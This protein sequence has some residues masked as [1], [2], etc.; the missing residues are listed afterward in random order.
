MITPDKVLTLYRQARNIDD[1]TLGVKETVILSW[2]PS[3]T[4]KFVEHFFAIENEQWLY[5]NNPIYTTKIGQ[6]EV[7]I[8][9]LKTGASASAIFIENL[10][11]CGAKKIICVGFSG[12]LQSDIGSGSLVFVSG[13][14]STEGTSRHYINN[15]EDIQPSAELL[16]NLEQSAD[17]QNIKHVKGKLWSTDALYR[18]LQSDVIR[19]QNQGVLGVDMESSACLAVAQ[20]NKVDLCS[21]QIVSDLLWGGRVGSMLR[22]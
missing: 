1:S 5:R 4:S 12:S 18:E 9:T 10:I 6:T 20:F 15:E 3:I 8:G 22:Q 17:A 14:V 11:A 13:C 21:I 2:L 7:S 16:A 19:Y